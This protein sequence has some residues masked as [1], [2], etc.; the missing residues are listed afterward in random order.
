MRKTTLLLLLVAFFF[1]AAAQ[2]SPVI[3]RGADEIK[4]NLIRVTEPLRAMTPGTSLV[5]D[6]IVRD[7]NGI[8]G[9]HKIPRTEENYPEQSF[10]GADPSLQQKYNVQAE[11]MNAA[12][13]G[14]NFNGMGVYS[15]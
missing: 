11:G 15:G 14:A 12:T 6:V 3:A 4:G 1:T 10:N 2:Q 7:E 13:V 9:S 8:I 5:K